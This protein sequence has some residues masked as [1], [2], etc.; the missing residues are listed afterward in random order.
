MGEA[1]EVTARR[2]MGLHSE[3]H[4]RWEEVGDRSFHLLA[5]VPHAVLGGA[6]PTPIPAQV[7]GWRSSCIQSD[8][9]FLK[10]RSQDP[11]SS[12]GEGCE[13]SDP[14]PSPSCTHQ[15]GTTLDTPDSAFLLEGGEG[16]TAI[17]CTPTCAL[18]PPGLQLLP[19]R[20]RLVDGLG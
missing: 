9:L 5:W 10:P 14:S 1:A 11:V 3:S 16:E 17:S 15:S 13:P 8:A 2:E 18:P 6:P 20:P 7:W 19:D 12:T 4:Q